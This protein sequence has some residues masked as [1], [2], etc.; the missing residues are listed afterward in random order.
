MATV[1]TGVLSKFRSKP[2]PFEA[3][4]GRASATAV[5][6]LPSYIAARTLPLWLP[7]V[8]ASPLTGCGWRGNK[9]SDRTLSVTSTWDASTLSLT[10]A[11][12]QDA[13]N[14]NDVNAKMA[15]RPPRIV[16]QRPTVPA[17]CMKAL[18]SD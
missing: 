7:L 14:P 6:S 12:L 10:V 5:T 18:R 4:C 13:S 3:G 17:R 9:S 16:G 1:A 15:A 8:A 2:L 11:E